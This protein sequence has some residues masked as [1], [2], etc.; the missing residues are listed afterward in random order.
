MSHFKREMRQEARVRVEQY[1][2]E[3]DLLLKAP[4][5]IAELEALILEAEEEYGSLDKRVKEHE[6]DDSA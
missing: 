4:E 2:R 5:R 1:R 3:R 6:K